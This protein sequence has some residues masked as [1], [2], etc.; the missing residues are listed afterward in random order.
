MS[1]IA[2]RN[3]LSAFTL[4]EVLLGIVI[5]SIMALCLSATLTAGIKLDKKSRGT[6]KLQRE[7]NLILRQMAKDMERMTFYDFSGSYAHRTAYFVVHDSPGFLISTDK[8]LRAVRY[9][10]EKPDS[11]TT[12]TT[13]IGTHSKK[14]LAVKTGSLAWPQLAVLV[15]EEQEFRKF[16]QSDFDGASRKIL[17]R[18]VLEGGL[19]IYHAAVSLENQEISWVQG[20]PGNSL[21]KGVRI[22]LTLKG[23]GRTNSSRTFVRDVSIPIGD[24]HE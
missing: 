7:A 2:V 5:F 22:A 13:R 8:G 17:S 14:N 6:I 21:P 10:L 23:S 12:V 1:K 3:G 20:W 4:V 19:K 11:G 18:F 15:R 16:L 24:W 9:I